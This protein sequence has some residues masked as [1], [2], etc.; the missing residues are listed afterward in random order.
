MIFLTINIQLEHFF[1]E[2]KISFNPLLI[3]SI[4]FVF[5]YKRGYSIFF[6]SSKI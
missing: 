4:R 5:T 6:V 2:I 3:D 1:L